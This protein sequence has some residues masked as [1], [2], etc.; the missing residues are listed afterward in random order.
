[1]EFN[2][3]EELNAYYEGIY[4]KENW[5]KND[6]FCLET[7]EEITEWLNAYYD[8]L[9]KEWKLR[10][11]FCSSDSVW[12]KYNGMAFEIVS[13]IYLDEGW[14]W[15]ALPAYNIKFI[16]NGE[17]FSAFVDEIFE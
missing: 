17:T 8:V 12:L 14:D 7:D 15:E 5:E 11:T 9:P 16:D 2:S 6:R 10:E 4:G 13:P 1:M 3:F